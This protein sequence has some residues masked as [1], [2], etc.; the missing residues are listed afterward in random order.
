M[1]MGSIEMREGDFSTYNLFY[2][3][4]CF[5]DSILKAK[6]SF[7]F[8][9]IISIRKMCSMHNVAN[10]TALFI[11]RFTM[12]K[13]YINCKIFLKTLRKSLRKSLEFNRFCVRKSLEFNRFCVR[14]T[15]CVKLTQG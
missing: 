2:N 9:Y 6:G 12:C 4:G 5:L 8:C 10:F 13:I 11:G 1:G 15:I 7:Y 3:N 14:L